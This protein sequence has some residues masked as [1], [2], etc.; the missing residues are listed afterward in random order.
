MDTAD[1]T[2][3]PLGRDAG[4]V[5]DVDVVD[6]CADGRGLAPAVAFVARGPA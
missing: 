4:R 2:V 1:A 6:F 3:T 5:V